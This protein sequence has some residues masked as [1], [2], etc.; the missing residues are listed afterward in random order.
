VAGTYPQGFYDD[1][2]AHT[3]HAARVVLGLVFPHLSP[4]R[5][6]DVGCGTGTWLAAALE[7]GAAH[8]E[9]IEGEWV[10]PDMLDDRRIA[11]AARDLELP[12]SFARRFDLALS[13]EVAEHLSPARAG[14]FV[15]DLV[16]AAPA[17]LFSAAVPGQGGVNHVNEQWQSFWAER[18][19]AHGHAP[20]DI[21]RPA[22][23]ADDAIPAWYRQN[24]V[25]YLAEDHPAAGRLPRAKIENL[26]IV[27][28]RFWERANRELAYAGALP[29]SEVLA[30]R[31]RGEA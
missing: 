18:F 30:R 24:V 8:A 21:V 12:F 3:A 25:L 9:G 22:V 20:Y 13:L 1:R 4:A 26:D 31:A 29:E 19:A 7:L 6:V 2:R 17:V 23:W 16:A 27:H 28:P 15:A 14:G 11:F 10:G 5:V